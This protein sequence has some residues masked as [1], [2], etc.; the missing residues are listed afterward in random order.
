[1]YAGRK[2]KKPVPKSPKT[3]L[4]CVKSNP[5]KRHR[6]RLNQELNKLTGLLPFPEDVRTRLDKLSILRLAVGYLKVK[7]YFMASGTDV[8]SHVLDQPKAP[9]GNGRTYLQANRASFP[10]GDLLLQALNGFLITVSGDGCIF[11][12]SPTVQDFL[13]FHQSDLIYQSV[14]E[15]I[16]I[17]DRATF[18]C[19][20]HWA[21]NP[22]APSRAKYTAHVMPVG[23]TLTAGYSTMYSPQH[24]PPE[25]T[26]F[27]ERSFIC[28][29]RCLLDNSSGFLALNFHGRLKLLHGLQKRAS[30]RSSVLP[31]LAL[32]AIATPLQPFSILELQTKTFIFQTKHK[33]DFTPTACDSRGKVVL[34]YTET[35][36]CMRGSGY[37]FVHVA[38]MMYCAENHVRMMK[39]GESGLTVFRLLTKKA[40]WVWVQAN[41]RLVYKGGQPD[42]IIARQRALS[43]EEG[44]EHL[45][46][47]N[48]QLP[49]SFATGEAVLYG[50][51]LPDFL[52]SF[53]TKEEFQTNKDSHMEQCSVDPSSLLEAMKKQDASVYV[54]HADNVLQF[55]LT[56]L[57]SEPDGPGQ[58][59]KASDT[60]E[61]SDSL[62]VII[63]TLFEKSEVDGNICQTLQNLSAD[64]MELQQWEETVFGLGAEQLTSQ[65][66]GERLGSGAN[67]YTEQMPFRKD[68]GKSMDFPHCSATVASCSEESSRA[69]LWAI[70][71]AA[72]VPLGFQTPLQCQAPD[73]QDQDAVVSL[74]SIM[75]KGNSAQP[76]QQVPFNP[77]GL[78]KGTTPG[79]SGSRSKPSVTGQLANP[80]QLF[81]G[82]DTSSLP[83]DSIVPKN[84]SQTGCQLMGSGYPPPL[85]SNALVTQWHNTPVL[86]NPAN[87]L[88]QSIAPGDCPS[89]AWVTV[90]PKKLGVVGMQMESQQTALAG[91]QQSVLGSPEAGLRLS[92]LQ[93]A[94]WPEQDLRK[95]CTVQFSAI[96]DLRNAAAALPV[97]ESKPLEAG[98]QPGNGNF[99]KQPSAPP[100]VSSFYWEGDWVMLQED[101]WL[102]QPRPQL[103]QAGTHPQGCSELI[104]V[105]HNSILLD[106]SMDPN[107]QQTEH[108]VLPQ[109]EYGNSKGFFKHQNTFLK[110]VPKI[111]L[112][113][114]PSTLSCHSESHPGASHY[115][116]GP[117]LGC[118]TT[119]PVEQCHQTEEPPAMEFTPAVA[120]DGMLFP[121]S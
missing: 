33:L 49:F 61:D 115:S 91:N 102:M 116:S 29:L 28:R 79:T 47:R 22:P 59:K 8:G 38:D 108:T 69:A 21:L 16:H 81:Q 107:T 111:S 87:A 119:L 2:R 75:S 73:A 71:S 112:P 15:L 39:T 64:N 54:S 92:P 43:N 6:D 25:N 104:P 24:L 68:T 18:H 58:E 60:K 82:K 96:E 31:Q 48:L 40:G 19:Q 88:G 89:E 101:K 93:P 74:V 32:F 94:P 27:M 70:S 14:Y 34:G 10:E 11:Y 65:N 3:P 103:V 118:S 30:S 26:S 84:Q 53:Q 110:D 7:S 86:A 109:W 95:S 121:K 72:P 78:V 57:I 35:E 77:A 85:D 17:D 56:D 66:T 67:A 44:E 51:D 36:L 12:V 4:E 106:N 41:A 117:M 46:K 98:Q 52:D 42:C 5:S 99:P 50:N 13:G 1:M 45:R 114:R 100:T 97:R 120:K 105:Q 90:A 76:E 80:G 37:Q 23:Q 62:L 83:A 113:Q 55:P 20:L 63:E 9:R